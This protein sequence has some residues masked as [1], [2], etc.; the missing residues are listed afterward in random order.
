MNAFTRSG[1]VTSLHRAALMGKSNTL[2][3]E[4]GK[5]AN[6]SF[7]TSIPRL[8]HQKIVQLLLQNGADIFHQDNDGN[9]ALHKAAQNR[10][11]DIIKLLLNSS[12]ESQR[13]ESICN[14]KGLTA[15]DIF[16]YT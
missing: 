16:E 15:K 7:Y 1:S 8:G 11:T 6:R 5:N 12:S 4:K 3:E 13:L 14:K 2:Y 9:T 10:H